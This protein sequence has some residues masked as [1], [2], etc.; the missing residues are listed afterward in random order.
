MPAKSLILEGY[1][2]IM[3]NP[4]N[5]KEKEYDTVD[6]TGTPVKSKMVGTR[7]KSIYVTADDVEVP[8]SQVCKKI[9]VEDEEIIAPKFQPTKEVCKDNITEVDDNGLIYRGIDR[10]FYNAVTDNEKIKDL[11]INQNKSIEFPFV[12]GAGWKIWKA[13]LTNWNGKLLLVACRGDIAKELEKY[14][15]ETVELEI[16]LMPQQANMKKMVMAMAMV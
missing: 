15:E 10:K 12:G 11:V 5:I 3:I 4:I 13:V 8:R 7:A 6:T 14:S 9:Q 16:E 1:G 2:N